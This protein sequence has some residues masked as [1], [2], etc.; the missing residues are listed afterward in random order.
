MEID[1]DAAFLEDLLN[2]VDLQG[3]R[4]APKPLPDPPNVNV[5]LDPN[6]PEFIP[7][8]VIQNQRAAHV[9]NNN[10]VGG[11]QNNLPAPA[12]PEIIDNRGVDHEQPLDRGQQVDEQRRQRLHAIIQQSENQ[13]ARARQAYLNLYGQFDNPAGHQGRDRHIANYDRQ[14]EERAQNHLER[15]QV[16]DYE[17]QNRNFNGPNRNNL[18]PQRNR[19][20]RY[21]RERDAA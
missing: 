11:R 12:K 1:D 10:H 4:R 19:G 9:G 2:N 18:G 8:N 5:D 21:Q 3:N 17:R 6:A 7:D 15:D 13:A 20:G 16:P 14:P